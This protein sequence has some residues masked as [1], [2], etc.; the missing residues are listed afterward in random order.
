[1][2]CIDAENQIFMVEL[3]P[4]A[5]Y[6][7]IIFSNNG[8]SQTA[9][10]DIPELGYIYTGSGWEEYEETKTGW[11]QAGKYWYYYDSNGKMV[12]G[13]QKISGKWYYLNA[14]GVMQTG[15]IKLNGKWYYLKSSGEMISGEKVTI[16]GKSYTF[17]SNGVWIK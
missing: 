6:T 8:A 12:T 5:G 15:W 1:M 10:L 9:D 7:K 2:E 11:Q 14:S 13:W 17:N 3:D 4:D 16:G